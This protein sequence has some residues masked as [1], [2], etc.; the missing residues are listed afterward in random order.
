MGRRRLRGAEVRYGIGESQNLG[1]RGETVC[2]ISDRL[3]LAMRGTRLVPLGEGW[4]RDG[5]LELVGNAV[6]ELAG[7][8]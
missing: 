8:P 6:M 5:V 4:R 7:V 1:H 3:R 2:E